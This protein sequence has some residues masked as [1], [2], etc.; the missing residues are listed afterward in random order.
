MAEQAMT[1]SRLRGREALLGE[2]DM[3]TEYHRAWLWGEQAREG[4]REVQLFFL[5]EEMEE[6]RRV[7]GGHPSVQWVERSQTVQV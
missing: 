7:Y 2:T 3:Q 5:A 1:H 4:A 6:G